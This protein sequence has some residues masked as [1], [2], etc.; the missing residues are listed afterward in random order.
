MISTLEG[1]L[2]ESGPLMAV[3]HTHGVGYEVQIPVTT[4]ERLPG[5]G[6]EVKL[7]IHPV[8]REDSATLY[9]FID[10]EDREF[11]R[12]LLE[13]VSGI[14]PRIALNILSR[15]SVSVLKEAI[16]NGDVTLLS[17]CPGIG[18]KTA[19]RL[20]MELR[21]KVF[22]GSS[23]APLQSASPGS[24]PLNSGQTSLFRD[25]VAAMMAL[26]Y[27]LPEAEKAIQRVIHADGEKLSTEELIKRA[28]Q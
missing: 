17:K 25:G 18:K 9:G 4:A 7:F 8:Y 16:A 6:K 14:G 5:L 2:A 24:V 21:D 10:R 11:F 23:P 22:S 13:K 12:L 3:I 26:G 27:K 1:T 28:L 15:M 20:V 19:E